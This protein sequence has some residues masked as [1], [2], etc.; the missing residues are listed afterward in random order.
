MATSNLRWRDESVEVAQDTL[1]SERRLSELDRY[2]V[3]DTSAEETF[4]RV[5]RLVCRLFG[6]K[7]ATVTF[8]DGHRQ[9]FKSRQ[10]MSEP[11]TTRDTSIC[12]Y[13][14]AQGEPLVI[15][16]VHDD[17]RF[18]DFPSVRGDAHLRFYA[19][20][21]IRSTHG[22]VI[23][24][25]CAM[26]VEPRQFTDKEVDLLCDLAR[27]VESEMEL[28]VL[29]ATD[30]LTQTL[31]RR[32]FHREAERAI[33]LAARHRYDLSCIV[34]DIDHFKLINDTDGHA[35]GDV[36][37]RRVAEI[38]Q[39]TL[40]PSDILGRIGGEEFA[41]ILPHA[42]PVGAAEV[43]ER[44][45]KAIEGLTIKRQ[46]RVLQTTASFG[47]ASLGSSALEASALVERAD[48]AMHQAKR[49][50][51]NCC[52]LWQGQET[53]QASLTRRVLK[54]ASIA[55]NGGRSVIDCT[56][57]RLSDQGARLDVVSS[58]GVPRK[59]KLNIA[60]EGFSRMC[61]VTEKDEKRLTVVFE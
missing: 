29:S 53:D 12:Q 43:A 39:Q 10:G 22:E 32:A 6:V 61:T 58:E 13:T 5:T 11:E 4:D 21:P 34:F 49:R 28:R 8:V 17:V 56:V 41:A 24:T 46:N 48:Q 54:A 33:A 42:S 59:F 31:S 18:C 60:T 35:A 52:V 45:R 36:V 2:D 38:S 20:A 30:S 26:D 37:L 23:G 16:N 44:L 27:L 55:F 7:M 50:A 57:R 1:N 9:W 15:E 19:G 25:L 51:R 3:L 14:V 47:V 40:R